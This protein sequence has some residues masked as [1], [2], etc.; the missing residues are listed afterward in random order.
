MQRVEK[1]GQV[2]RSCVFIERRRDERCFTTQPPRHAPP[3]GKSTPG[4]A[5]P[6]RGR[7]GEGQVRRE[8]REP[9]LFVFDERSRCRTARQANR[10]ILAETERPVV[11][12]FAGLDNGKCGEVG[13]LFLQQRADERYVNEHFR[14]RRHAAAY[15][16]RRDPSSPHRKGASRTGK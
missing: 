7:N 16:R 3:P 11:P 12:P 5:Y 6:N 14:R 15:T 2:L 9:P 10:Q 8:D 1:T 4:S 13:M